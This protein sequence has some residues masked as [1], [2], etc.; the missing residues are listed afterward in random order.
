VKQ[1]FGLAITCA[2]L[3][4]CDAASAT[5]KHKGG[6]TYKE[7]RKLAIAEGIPIRDPIWGQSGHDDCT[8]KCLLLTQSEHC[9]F[10]PVI[11][12]R[13]ARWGQVVC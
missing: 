6:R 12:A 4:L 9:A 13:G 8:A 10:G 2:V 3:I 7:C 5:E 1:S 11:T